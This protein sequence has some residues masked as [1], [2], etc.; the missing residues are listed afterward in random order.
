MQICIKQSGA[1]YRIVTINFLKAVY[2]ITGGQWT[3]SQIRPKL[4]AG[5]VFNCVTHVNTSIHTRFSQ[6]KVGQFCHQ[7]VVEV[8]W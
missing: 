3:V 8:F 4:Q 2:R 7:H 1:I 6:M 5:F